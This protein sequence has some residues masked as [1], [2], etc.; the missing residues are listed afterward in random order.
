VLVPVSVCASVPVS[1]MVG[2]VLVEYT[3]AASEVFETSVVEAAVMLVEDCPVLLSLPPPQDASITLRQM[4]PITQLGC[5]MIV[6]IS[7]S[8]LFRG[9]SPNAFC[10]L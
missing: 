5:F 8:S 1:V 4:M 3:V 6:S 7:S 9:G 2:Q 10:V